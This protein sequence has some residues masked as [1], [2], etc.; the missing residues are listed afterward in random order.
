[1]FF[2]QSGSSTVS[3]CFTQ[4]TETVNSTGNGGRNTSC[5]SLE[6]SR[7]ST[8][9]C[10]KYMTWLPDQRPRSSGMDGMNSSTGAENISVIVDTLSDH[11]CGDG[12][13]EQ[14]V[15][16]LFQLLSLGSDKCAVHHH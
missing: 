14:E 6:V 10:I 2:E 7:L 13:M 12:Q 15:K 1:M 16:A 4:A 8:S 5:T 3:V 11:I 9:A